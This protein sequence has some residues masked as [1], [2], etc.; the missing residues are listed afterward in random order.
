MRSMCSAAAQ[1]CQSAHFHLTSLATLSCPDAEPQALVLLQTLAASH[2]PVVTPEMLWTL[3]QPMVLPSASPDAP[4]CHH[5][6]C[7]RT[8]QAMCQVAAAPLALRLLRRSA[9]SVAQL[10]TLEQDQQTHAPPM[11]AFSP[12]PDAQPFQSARF[13]LTPQVTPQP[14]ATLPVP[15]CLKASAQSAVPQTM[16]V[17]ALMQL[18]PAMV[19]PLLCL[20]VLP[21]AACLPLWKQATQQSAAQAPSW[22]QRVQSRAPPTTQAHQS[23][24]APPLEERSHSLGAQ[25]LPSAHCLSL[26]LTL[27]QATSLHFATLVVETHMASQRLSV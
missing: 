2:A 12:S 16:V 23:Q 24:L 6:P 17:L 13:P 20:A 1:L 18:A 11:V 21:C 9:A 19:V 22:P 5:A 15:S 7:Q 8:P 10:T 27:M 25:Q 26:T 14:A 3:A 4:Q